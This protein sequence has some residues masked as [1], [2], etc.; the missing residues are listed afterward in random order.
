M[1]RNEKKVR[2][3]S[4]EAEKLSRTFNL[5]KKK[6]KEN[7]IFC[8]VSWQKKQIGL[9]RDKTPVPPP[10][11]NERMNERVLIEMYLLTSQVYVNNNKLKI[12]AI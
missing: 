11:L 3:G 5:R 4:H 2:A 1:E 10:P 7:A 6:K 9:L 8:S 12:I